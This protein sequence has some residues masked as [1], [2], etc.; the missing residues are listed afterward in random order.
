MW[1]GDVI[2]SDKETPLSVA[3]NYTIDIFTSTTKHMYYL[4]IFN[5]FFSLCVL[6]VDRV[7]AQDF[8]HPIPMK[9]KGADTYYIQATIQGLGDTDFMVDTGSGYVTINENSLGT[10]QQQGEAVYVKNIVGKLADGQLKVVPIY[11][12][13]TINL[14]NECILK[15]VEAAVFPGKTRQILGLS[16]LKKAAPFIFSFN[17]PKLILSHCAAPA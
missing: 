9:E 16:G 4:L 5:L 12:I 2:A 15:D 6:P 3:N 7:F 11:R 1:T 10:L 8:G 17:P 14:G 13:S